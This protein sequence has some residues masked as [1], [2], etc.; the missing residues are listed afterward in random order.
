MASGVI[1]HD[2]SPRM[3][4]ELGMP[5]TGHRYVRVA[6][7]ILLIAV[8]TGLVV[9]AVYDLNNMQHFEFRTHR[10]NDSKRFLECER[11]KPGDWGGALK[12]KSGSIQFPFHTAR[13]S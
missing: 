8:G 4:I 1:F 12:C 7:D 6:Q 11:L 10:S 5:P 2:L 3:V 13:F 9:D